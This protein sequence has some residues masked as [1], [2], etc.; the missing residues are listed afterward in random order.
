ME[1]FKTINLGMHNSSHV[2]II[3]YYMVACT[4]TD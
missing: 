3:T 4:L 2:D 1:Q